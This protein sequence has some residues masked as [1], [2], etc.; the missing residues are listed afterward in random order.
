MAADPHTPKR[1]TLVLISQ[2]YVPDPA[3]VGQYMHDAAAM[4]AQRGHRVVVY[5]SRR[6]YADPAQQYERA[7]RRDGVEVRRLPLSSL[8]KHS[9]AA[10]LVGG[11]LFLV[12]A[13]VHA[14]FVRRL[15]GVIVST[16]PPM[17]PLAAL[18]LRML[19]RVP[20]VFWAMDINPDQMIAMGRAAATSLPARLF[21]CL[22]RRTLHRAAQTVTLD[23]YMADRLRMKVNVGDR[24]RVI[25]PWPLER[26]LEPV[27]HDDNALR[28]A[29]GLCGRFVVMYSG[30]LS[31]AHPLDTLLDAAARLRD[32]RDPV[33][34]LVGDG[35]AKDGIAQRIERERLDNVRLL[36]YQPLEML[37]DSLSAADLHVVSM[38]EAM[39]GIVH[40]CKLYGAMAVAR[41]VLL[42]G[43]ARSHAGEIIEAHDIGRCIAHGDTD[44]VVRALRELQTMGDAALT[45]MGRRSRRAVDTGFTR[46]ALCGTFCDGVE[47][48]LGN[49][50]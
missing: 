40:P 26:H 30:N 41:P 6:G 14:M 23:R 34:L 20:F 32:E 2:V 5:T 4:L 50:R 11:M 44:G 49:R 7:E 39:V 33:F 38:G 45:D 46:Q 9:M 8:G 42:I 48:M 25:P 24:L 16:S 1:S 35:L 19:R 3:A 10:R 22:I 29:H 17:A 13:T 27:A 21:D 12:Q 43:P 47:R 31:T 28:T 36:P 18:W 15:S 37:R